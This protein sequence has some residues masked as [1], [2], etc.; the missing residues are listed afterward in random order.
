M[1]IQIQDFVAIKKT[2]VKTPEGFLRAEANITRIGDFL[3]S[4]GE[5][6]L[7]SFKNIK[8]N[9]SGQHKIH[10]T[11]GTVNNP[12]TLASIKG[13]PVTL[14]HPKD[15]VNPTNWRT[16]TVGNLVGNPEYSDGVVKGDLVICED[17]AIKQV[18]GGLDKLSIGYS[19]NVIEKDGS[20]YTDGPMHV[21]HVALVE[22]P[23]AGPNFRIKDE[24]VF[25]T[26]EQITQLTTQLAASVSDAVRKNS[27]GVMGS[28][29]SDIK[30]TVSDAIEPLIKQFND[31]N[32]KQQKVEDNL[33]AKDAETKAKAAADKL[34]KATQDEMKGE[35]KILGLAKSLSVDAATE[36]KDDMSAKDALITVLGDRLQDGKSKSVEF[37][38]AFA[39]GILSAASTD[40]RGT[41]PTYT[42]VN[43]RGDGM[44]GDVDKAHQEYVKTL[45]DAH[46]PNANSK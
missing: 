17:E 9:D 7:S 37:L 21:N 29:E 16:E 42:P 41:S 4:K 43:L 20:L 45:Q 1:I 34:V 23:R 40:N 24:E 3:Y 25:M 6:D 15:G 18:E 31:L 39:E 44:T 13:A 12:K 38:S 11:E 22:H 28:G 26:P 8:P 2:R 33:A 14:G 32:A 46:K 5:I 19:I 30:K 10:R 35:F 36:I 27:S